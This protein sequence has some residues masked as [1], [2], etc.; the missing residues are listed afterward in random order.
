MVEIPTCPYCNQ[1][2]VSSHAV[3]HLHDVEEKLRRKLAD[4]ANAAASRQFQEK[5][6]EVERERSE[7]ER[8]LQQTIE[9]LQKQKEDLEGKAQEELAAAEKRLRDKM[10]RERS[11][12][13]R[14]LQQT[15]ADLRKHSEDLEQRSQEELAA[16]EKQIRDEEA[17][18][19][20]KH[21][22]GLQLTIDVL[23]RQNRD[24]ERRLDGLSAPDR[25][26]INEADIARDLTEA[27]PDDEIT[28]TGKCGDIVQ[29]VRYRT[30]QRLEQAGVILYE[31]KDTKNWSNGFI[32]QVKADGRTLH[33]PYLL[34]VSKTLPGKEK[35]TC[36]SDDVIVADPP[37]ARHLARILRRM[38]IETHRAELAGQDRAAKTARLYEYLRGDEF[39]E[40]LAAVVAAGNKLTDMLQAERKDHER[41]WNKRQQAY[42]EL[43]HDSVAIEE[44]I[45]GIIESA[46]P[47]NTPK[48]ARTNGGTTRTPRRRSAGAV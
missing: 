23:Q 31:C 43:V 30:D 1:P 48:A 6:A 38:V 3:A 15:I 44:T 27:F 29:V 47:Q 32:T 14:A 22:Q 42:D 34:L 46:A 40:Q 24:L 33:T 35:G 12:Q 10:E 17:H 4:D 16:A 39:R 41:G 8:G 2:L 26:A 25:G 21:E 18:E 11:E 9:G 13:E 28:R 7:Q 20:S 45:Q 36:V 19:R 37:H 5:L